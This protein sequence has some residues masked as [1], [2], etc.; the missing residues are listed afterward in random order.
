MRHEAREISG[1]PVFVTGGSSGIGL[2]FAHHCAAKGHD[3][4]IFARDPDRLNGAAQELRAA[5]PD[6]S[7]FHKVA[8]VTDPDAMQ[9]ALS[10]AA[11]AL[12]KPGW[13]VCSAGDTL[14][15]YWKTLPADAEERLMNVNYFGVTN[16]IRQCLPHLRADA[17]IGIVSSAAAILGICGYGAYAPSKFA[18]RG[19]AEILRTELARDG[20]HVT[21]Y[22]PPDTQT[23]QYDREL[24]IR[25]EATR[26]VS[27]LGGVLSAERVAQRLYDAMAARRFVAFPTLMLRLY[28]VASPI[29]APFFRAY[30]K[31]HLNK[32]RD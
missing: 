15:G 5:H 25:P 11:Q 10:A 32:A 2:A 3:V 19:L 12:G 4:A 31:W 18:L 22:M 27:T 21:L 28:Y 13:L 7:F 8:D 16:T 6:V 1:S 17:R 14:P 26:R 29:I 30:Q 24:P 23:P 20:V 9:G